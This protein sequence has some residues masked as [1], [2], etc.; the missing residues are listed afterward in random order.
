MNVGDLFVYK[1]HTGLV[2][3]L[4]VTDKRVEIALL[5]PQSLGF[6]CNHSCKKEHVRPATEDEL[7]FGYK[8]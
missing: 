7:I 6:I 2:E 8:L 4:K 1:D 5:N 3:I